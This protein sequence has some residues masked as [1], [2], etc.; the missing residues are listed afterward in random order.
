ML[1]ACWEGRHGLQLSEMHLDVGVV[2]GLQTRNGLEMER[3]GYSPTD[4]ILYPW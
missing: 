2:Q 4:A 3:A 1:S